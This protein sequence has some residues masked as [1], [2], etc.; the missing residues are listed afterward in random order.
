MPRGKQATVVSLT[1]GSWKNGSSS[2]HKKNE[3][4]LLDCRDNAR[5]SS[6]FKAGRS[7]IGA[8][9]RGG[10]ACFTQ[11]SQ[12]DIASQDCNSPDRPDN[13]PSR[14]HRVLVSDFSLIM[15]DHAT[16]ISGLKGTRS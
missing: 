9:S 11:D 10:I 1:A 4:T 8:V 2:D 12:S 7:R 16:T 15:P 5:Q 13:N 6:S 14:F 3:D